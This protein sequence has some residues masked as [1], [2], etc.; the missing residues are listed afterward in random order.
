MSDEKRKINVTKQGKKYLGMI[1]IPSDM[2]RTTDYFNRPSMMRHRDNQGTLDSFIQLYD[3]DILIGDNIVLKRQDVVNVRVIDIV[4]YWDEIDNLG[5]PAEQKRA[6]AMME[7]M[8][9][10]ELNRVTVT[11]PMHGSQ[12]YEISGTFYGKF[13]RAMVK[14]FLALTNAAVEHFFKSPE[15]GKWSKR[16]VSLPHD[17]VALNMNFVDSYS[18]KYEE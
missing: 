3:A 6:K 14:N 2:Y 16:S 7:Q 17:F 10:A 4:F 12:F 9:R 18:L 15:S 5:M 8:G 11:T 13:K 1:S